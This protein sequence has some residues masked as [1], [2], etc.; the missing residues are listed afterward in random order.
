[1]KWRKGW[2][3]EWKCW[4][5]PQVFW[6]KSDKSNLHIFDLSCPICRKYWVFPTI[7]TF[8][9]CRKYCSIWRICLSDFTHLLKPKK[10]WSISDKSDMF[11]LSEI[12]MQIIKSDKSDMSDLSLLIICISISDKS[13]MSVLSEILENATNR[14]KEVILILEKCK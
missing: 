12:L 1:M 14:T 6:I 2:Q 11:D 10:V 7:R 13:N 8:P 9:I 5:S 3:W 4:I